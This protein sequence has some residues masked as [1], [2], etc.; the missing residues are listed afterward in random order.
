MLRWVGRIAASSLTL[1]AVLAV[2][3]VFQ[4]HIAAAQSS[5]Q[6]SGLGVSHP[7][8]SDDPGAPSAQAQQEQQERRNEPG[9]FDFYVLALS[10]SPSYCEA[11]RERS[12]RTPD[13]QQCGP[14]PYSFV[15]HGLW[16]QYDRGFPSY[17]QVP[18]PRLSR[19]IVNEM[20]D[21]MPS[22]RLVYHEWDRHGTCSGLSQDAFFD[23]VR[24]AR[25]AVRIPDRFVA[26]AAPLV[27]TPHDVAD[28]FIAANPGLSRSGLAIACDSKR[29]S[30]IRICLNKDLR[31]RDC[32]DV[33]R[34][35][36]RRD[37]IVM[38]PVRGARPALLEL[39]A[40]H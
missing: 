1:S 21:V 12:N 10:W 34:R 19:N 36:C 23:N 9:R 28:A 5:G 37:S 7:D 14:R 29:L 2:A 15:V 22:P 17:C 40:P 18:S 11:S 25:A 39:I 27:V 35:S 31:F 3:F 8:P 33:A 6:D 32:G 24:K 4:A 26:I 38:P 30:E 16:P 13:P 20:L